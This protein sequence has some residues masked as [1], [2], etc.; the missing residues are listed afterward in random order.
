MN[1]LLMLAFACLAGFK[2]LPVFSEGGSLVPAIVFLLMFGAPQLPW[3]LVCSAPRPSRFRMRVTL[4]IAC[5]FLCTS[6]LFGYFPGVAP[7]AWGG[8]GRFEVP[9][10]LLVEGAVSLAGLIAL[11]VFQGRQGAAGT[12]P[13]PDAA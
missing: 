11:L 12:P 6:V 13:R 4:L 7:P 1:L 2:F 3:V 8:E 5:V 10:A 9:V